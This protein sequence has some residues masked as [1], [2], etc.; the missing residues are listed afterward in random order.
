[1][2]R[3]DDFRTLAERRLKLCSARSEGTTS[4]RSKPSMIRLSA[5]DRW[6]QICG[7]TVFSTYVL[8]DCAVQPIVDSP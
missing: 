3:G 6:P 7:A 8:F 4:P 1:V 2:R 5:K